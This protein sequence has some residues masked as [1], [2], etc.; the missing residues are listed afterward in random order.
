MRRRSL[1]KGLGELISGEPLPQGHPVIAVSIGRLG[2]NPRQPRVQVDGDKL[3]ELTLSVEAHGILQPIMVRAAGED[4]EI[5]AGERRWRAAQRA[6]LE[7][8]PCVVLDVSDE[9]SLELALVEN[10]QREDLNALEAARGYQRLVEDFGLTQEQLSQLI[11]KSRSAIANTLRLLD[12]PGPVQEAIQIGEITEGHGRALL[13]L[14]DDAEGL[15]EVWRAVVADGMTVRDTERAVRERV[16]PVTPSPPP[17]RARRQEPDPNLRDA[18]ERI[19][20]AMATKVVIRPNSRGG[21][22]IEIAYS[23]AEE[24]DRLL[25]LLSL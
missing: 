19:Q 22:K 2:P 17:R 13:G 16:S 18:Q 1:G 6:G 3:E 15:L 10:L 7:T 5:V 11:G 4:Y 12:L 14:G 8:V 9:Q 21:G 25:G 23:D 20:T 24:F